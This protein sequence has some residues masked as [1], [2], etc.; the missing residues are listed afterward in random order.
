[1]VPTPLTQ[2]QHPQALCHV[3]TQRIAG[4]S[5]HRLETPGSGFAKYSLRRG[6]IRLRDGQVVRLVSRFGSTTLPVHIDS[7]IRTGQLF[8]TFHTAK[9]FLNRVTGP[10]RDGVVGTPEYKVVA[11]RIEPLHSIS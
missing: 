10:H 5:Q 11:V 2:S 1:M 7:A 9:S 6:K 3:P 4:S 8:A